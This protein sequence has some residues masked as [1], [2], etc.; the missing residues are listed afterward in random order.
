MT[1]TGRGIR[2]GTAAPGGQIEERCPQQPQEWLRPLVA[3][4]VEY[5][6][7][8]IGSCVDRLLPTINANRWFNFGALLLDEVRR[9]DLMAEDELAQTTLRLEAMRLM[10]DTQPA[11]PC[12]PSA[13]VR[14]Y[15]AC[16]D[17]NPRKGPIDMDSIRGILEHGLETYLKDHNTVEKRTFVED[18]VRQISLIVGYGPF[19]GNQNEL[20]T[21]TTRFAERHFAVYSRAEPISTVLATFLALSFCDISTTEDHAVLVT[22][23]R[24]QC[25]AAQ[26]EIDRMLT[27]S[28]LGGLVGPNDVEHAFNTYEQVFCRYVDDSLW[29]AFK[30]PLTSGEEVRLAATFR[31]QLMRLKPKLAE[32]SLKVKYGG[33]SAELRQR[34]IREVSHV[35]RQLLVQT[36]YLR[37]PVYPGVSC[38][39]RGSLGF[40]ATIR[41][42]FYMEGDRAKEKFRAMKYFH[43]G[44]RLQ[45][46]VEREREVARHDQLQDQTQ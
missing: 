14:E 27:D 36:A 7:P 2:T 32:I 29:P 28:E 16:L 41:D 21:A 1:A 39:Y 38:H 33:V 5:V 30:F 23:F 12:D 44:H 15:L 34:T 25:A 8:D 45:D 10:K 20:T 17:A 19:R 22:Q 42:P 43:L 11:D 46:V 37:K 4:T 13:R 24:G 35:A 18:I 6:G 3:Q 26:W 40:T 9:Q 31:L